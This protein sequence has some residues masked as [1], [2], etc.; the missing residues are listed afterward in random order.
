M[1]AQTPRLSCSRLQAGVSAGSWRSLREYHRTVW[2]CV[3]MRCWL[4][5]STCQVSYK[6]G[7]P[8]VVLS[9]LLA[10]VLDKIGS[11]YGLSIAFVEI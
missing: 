11:T 4:R 6:C 7:A 9:I 5:W 10:A 2:L 1:K 8:C 3:R